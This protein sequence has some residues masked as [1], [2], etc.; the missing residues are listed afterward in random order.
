ML[1]TKVDQISSYVERMRSLKEPC[2]VL[3]ASSFCMALI[4]AISFFFASETQALVL[5]ASIGASIILV[6]MLPSSPLSQPYPLLAGQTISAAIG[7]FCAGFPLDLYFSA[8]ICIFV[9]MLV[10][11]LLNCLHPPAGATALIP[12]LLGS[13]AVG[14]YGYVFFPVLIN[15]FTLVVSGIIFHRWLLSNEYPCHPPSN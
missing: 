12:V 10:M 15:M 9:C 5:V 14:G 11:S 6:F 7:V 1:E 13:Q 2:M 4:A 3:M 8:P